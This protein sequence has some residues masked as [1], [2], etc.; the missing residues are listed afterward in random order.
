METSLSFIMSE[1]AAMATQRNQPFALCL[2][3]IRVSVASK[4]LWLSD[5]MGCSDAA[6]S[7]WESGSRLPSPRTI[8]RLLAVL[9]DAGAPASALLELR[10]AWLVAIA[11][12]RAAR[13]TRTR[14]VRHES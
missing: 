11:A 1:P 2:K 12:R 5:C 6:V 3:R 7:L 4:Q 9:A 13:R 10:R 8:D 14:R